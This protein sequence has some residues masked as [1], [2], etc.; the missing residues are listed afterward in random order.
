MSAITERPRVAETRVK[1]PYTLPPMTG[2]SPWSTVTKRANEEEPNTLANE[3][4]T[5][6]IVRR[7]LE[8]DGSA[9]QVVEEQSSSSPRIK[10]AL[11]AASKAGSGGGK[12]EFIVTFPAEAPNL[13]VVI[14]CK[15]NPA[16]HESSGGDRPVDFAV[17]GVLLYSAHL[18][19]SFDV[20][21]VAV[22]GTTKDHLKVSV[23]KQLK[24]EAKA[25]PLN[26]PHGPIDTLIPVDELRRLL[27][28]DDQVQAR[29]HA[30][31]LTF[32][33]E[34]HDFMRDYARLSEPQKPLVVSAIL[35]ALRDGVFVKNWEGYNAKDQ[36]R[37]VF[38]ALERA[39]R[40][41]GLS[42]PQREIILAAYSFIKTHPELS[43][44]GGGRGA[45][46]RESPLHQLI[47]DI[48]QHVRPFI[49]TY[50]DIDVIG[51]FYGEFLR[52]TGGDSR[53]LGIVL[54]P[55]HLT[56]LFV[57]IANVGPHD[58]VVDTCAGTAGFLISSLSA[59]DAKA[60]DEK[61]R[62]DIRQHHLI[63]VEQQ[64]EMYALAVANMILRGDGKS[65]L[66]R[67]DC[68]DQEITEKLTKGV[69]GRHDRPNIGLINPPY[70][71]KR[72]GTHEL[73][74]VDTL[75]GI[76]TPGGLAVAVVPM[77]CAI[78]GHPSRE[79]ILSKHTLVASMSL[80]NDLFVN[81]GTVTCALVFRAHQPHSQAPQP[82]WFGYWKKDGFVKTKDR[83]RID[84][85]GTWPGVRDA[86][87][88]DYFSRTVKPG[89]SI[90]QAVSASDEWCAEA[91]L[92]TD[93]AAL[94]SED[95]EAA[96]RKYAM[97]RLL[98]I[99]DPSEV[100]IE[101]EEADV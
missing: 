26:S 12:P 56:E 65:N 88:D 48:D 7:H 76:L 81:I 14:E 30:E 50:T 22:S 68:F 17:D 51:Q 63:G 23:F 99:A 91:Y 61:T 97:F 64:P 18:A 6:E 42:E 43:K 52:Y 47:A 62:Q 75:L 45:T 71:Q 87:L 19:K 5:E 9:G 100:S 73:D 90:T 77:S 36:A 70:S 24:G 74:F 83:G 53:G 8:R 55:R 92:E 67:G 11:A 38:R 80:P 41:S 89:V 60:P 34:L 39:A 59:M 78:A 37:E 33:R 44:T 101:D 96:L 1:G 27:T 25:S 72:E 2:V 58:T 16:R 31:L 13:V 85:H 3:R 95:F 82:T 35:L 86:W 66:Y 46:Q 15:A 40:D 28:Y 10:R 84:L 57:G 94:K 93:Y 69:P 4:A 20:I 32:S 98:Q 49:D 54:T 79:R 21:A 29:T